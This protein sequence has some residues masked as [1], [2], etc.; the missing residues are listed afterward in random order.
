MKNHSEA[1]GRQFTGLCLA[2]FANKVAVQRKTKAGG[3]LG[4]GQLLYCLPP[5]V[6]FISGS[7]SPQALADLPCNK[8]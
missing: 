7:P 8:V 4:L 2:C 3:F 1:S 5:L 6:I